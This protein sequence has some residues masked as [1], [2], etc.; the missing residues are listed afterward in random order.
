[1]VISAIQFNV[2]EIHFNMKYFGLLFKFSFKFK[3]NF[4]LLLVQVVGVMVF[5]LF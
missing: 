5:H 3:Y 4:C 2:P 1:M